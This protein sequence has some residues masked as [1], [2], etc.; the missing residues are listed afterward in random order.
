M[1]NGL[2]FLSG[3]PGEELILK[4][5]ADLAEGHHNIGTCLVRIAANRLSRAGIPLPD[6]ISP[7]NAELDLYALLTPMGNSAHSAYNSLIRQLISFEQ[8]L[9]HRLSRAA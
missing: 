7:E 2:S 8:S 5:I 3:L 1:T 6:G 4:G 9:D